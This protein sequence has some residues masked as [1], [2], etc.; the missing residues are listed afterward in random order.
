ME[1]P[2]IDPGTSRLSISVDVFGGQTFV[3]AALLYHFS[4]KKKKKRAFL[5]SNMKVYVVVRGSVANIRNIVD[6][7]GPEIIYF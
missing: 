6:E 7:K 5:E 1:N 2:G 4:P 3:F